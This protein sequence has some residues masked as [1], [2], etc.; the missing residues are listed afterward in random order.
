MSE[1]PELAGILAT[2]RLVLED[3]KYHFGVCE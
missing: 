3:Y 2:D 1:D